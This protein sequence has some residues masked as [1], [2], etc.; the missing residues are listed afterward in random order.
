MDYPIPED[1]IK[2]KSIEELLKN[3]NYRKS[4]WYNGTVYLHSYND[5]PFAFEL[6]SKK[7]SEFYVDKI[8]IKE[9]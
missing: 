7:T 1:Y 5:K 6:I 3:I 8:Y 4:L 2:V 9:E